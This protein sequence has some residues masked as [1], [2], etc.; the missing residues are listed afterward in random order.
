M[1]ETYAFDRQRAQQT[2][3]RTVNA[4]DLTG[5]VNARVQAAKDQAEARE[6]R[7]R[8]A[9]DLLADDAA[10]LPLLRLLADNKDLLRELMADPYALRMAVALGQDALANARAEREAAEEDAA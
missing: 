8:A 3:T 2:S 1:T 4:R 6:D 5:M 9:L 10:L 7:R